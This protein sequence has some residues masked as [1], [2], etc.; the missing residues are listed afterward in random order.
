MH[1]IRF[2]LL[3]LFFT[4]ISAFAEEGKPSS[5]LS[6]LQQLGTSFAQNEQELLPPDQAFKLTVRVRDAN[7]LVAEFEPTKN[8]YLYKDKI[9][10]KPQSNGTLIEKILLPQG[11]MKNDLTFGQTEVYYKPFQAVISLKREASATNQLTLVA[12]YQGCNEPIGVCYAPIDKIIKLTLPVAKAAVGVMAET[13]S[14]DATAATAF[15]DT[16]SDPAAELFQPIDRTLSIETESKRIDRMFEGGDFWLILTSFF[17]IGLLLSFTPCVFPM[18]PI[19]SGIIVNRGQHITKTHGFILALAYVMG[20]SLAYSAAGVAAGLS[21]AMLSAAL[22]NAWVL[23]GFALVFVT[24][25]FSMFGFYELQLPS[26]LQS[27]LSEEAGHLKGGHLTSVFGMGALSALIVGPCVA[28]PLAGAL[29]YISQ[30]RDVVLGASALFTMALGMG[31]PLLLLGASA[32]ALLPKAGPWMESVKRFFGVLLLGVAIW[33]ISPVLPA[34]VHMLMWAALLIVS[35]I[36]LHAVDAL[37]TRASGFQKFLKGLG[38]IALLFGVALLVGVLSGSRDILQPLSKINISRINEKDAN[39]VNTDEFKHLPFQRVSSL[40]E[41]NK[42][43]EQSQNKYVML[44]FYADW[45]ISCKE[46]ERF[47]FTDAKIKS[48]LKDVVLLQV[49][50]TAG[51]LDDDV[52][53]KHF[54][55]FGPPGILFFDR[56]GRIIPDA[57]VIGYQSTEDFLAILSAVLI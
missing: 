43:I 25:A 42:R 5:L 41:L 13:V 38:I 57:R 34:A 28:A 22:Q 14:N 7:T 10:F 40:V 2:F 24:L 53:L 37:P 29:L 50:V 1:L 18:F 20:M 4:S 30:T 9:A 17:G 56:H 47:T 46:M 39:R 8:Y 26:S 31:V 44:D 6:G 19:L 27:K 15:I 54:K 3:L 49:D 55:L 23:G 51:T 12:T 11:K 16:K 32:G 45:C 48:K 33:L 52:L 36:Y 35:A 21:G